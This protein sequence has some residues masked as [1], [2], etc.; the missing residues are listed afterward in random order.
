MILNNVFGFLGLNAAN[1]DVIIT[2]ED[3]EEYRMISGFDTQEILKIK[4]TFMSYTNGEEYM[5]Y[6]SF[7]AIPS[8][9]VNPLKDRI[10]IVFGIEENRSISFKD[11][12]IGLSCFNSPGNI[13]QKLKTAFRLQDF[14]DDNVLNGTDLRIYLSRLCGNNLSETDMDEIIQNMFQECS[15][16]DKLECINFNDFQR[17]VSR[18]DFQTKLHIPL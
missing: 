9:E 3:I 7:T 1:N 6:N 13:E 17:V 16:D 4:K 8:I 5:T 11:F 14:D 10:C 12:L 15:S 2:A 18:T